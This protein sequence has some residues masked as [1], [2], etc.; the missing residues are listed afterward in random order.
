M[1][2]QPI[3]VENIAF[4]ETGVVAVELLNYKGEVL[5]GIEGLKTALPDND[6]T[7]NNIIYLQ[8]KRLGQD[9]SD[10][11]KK[12]VDDERINW[13]RINSE[14][15]TNFIFVKVKNNNID[16]FIKLINLHRAEVSKICLESDLFNKQCNVNIIKEN[17]NRLSDSGFMLRTG[18]VNLRGGLSSKG[19]LEVYPYNKRFG[20]ANVHDCVG[21]LHTSNSQWKLYI[22]FYNFSG[23]SDYSHEIE[24]NISISTFFKRNGVQQANRTFFIDNIEDC[25]EKLNTFFNLLHKS[26]EFYGNTNK[27][28]WPYELCSEM[29]SQFIN[30]DKD[31]QKRKAKINLL[32]SLLNEST[33][34]SEIDKKYRSIARSCDNFYTKY[35]ATF[36]VKNNN[37]IISIAPEYQDY[38]KEISNSDGG[39]MALIDNSDNEEDE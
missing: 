28:I 15:P 29:I 12:W 30:T 13:W 39:F 24:N 35:N 33:A 21:F 14:K 26:I 38:L 2:K 4:R 27:S 18:T 8:N 10:L 22:N 23:Y 36:P 3:S 1:P 31:I 5:L 9:N 7:K 37:G 19:M 17:L 32:E 25:S 16:E 34:E 11:S 6:W 20:T